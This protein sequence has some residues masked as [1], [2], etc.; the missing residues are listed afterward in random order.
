MLSNTY[1]PLRTPQVTLADLHRGNGIPRPKEP[2]AKS[3]SSRFLIRGSPENIP[4][5]VLVEPR[6]AVRHIWGCTVR[7]TPRSPGVIAKREQT[8]IRLKPRFTYRRR[9][10]ARPQ[11]V[12]FEKG[13]LHA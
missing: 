8:F 1:A 5:D 4:A 12:P 10:K 13:C 11:A 2:S 7:I 3:H 6:R 9:D